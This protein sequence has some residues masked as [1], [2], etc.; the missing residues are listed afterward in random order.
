MRA[1]ILVEIDTDMVPG[2]GFHPEDYVRHIQ[3]YLDQTIPH[4][5][6]KVTLCE[7]ENK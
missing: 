2:W 6:P 3:R 4:Y 5:N 1:K 7:D